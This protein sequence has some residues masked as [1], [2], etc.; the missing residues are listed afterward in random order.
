MRAGWDRCTVPSM[1]RD[2]LVLLLLYCLPLGTAMAQGVAHLAPVSGLN[3]LAA[4]IA[5]G[6]APLRSDLAR[7]A[8]TELA[9]VYADEAERAHREMRDRAKQRELSS[10]AAAV[11]DLAAEFAAL[12]ET[13]TPDTPVQVSIGP[14]HG[15][16]LLVEGRPVMVSSPRMREQV[17]FEQRVIAHFCALNQC[18]GL[19]DEPAMAT[20]A[21]ATGKTA[22]PQWSFSQVAGPVCG[23]G[24]G[25]EFQFMNADNIGRKR[26][27]CARIVSE[28]NTL[29]TALTQQ[30]AGGIRLDWNRLAIHPLPDGDEQVILNGEGDYLRLR[31]PVL[32]ARPE[33]FA[34]LR[35]WLAAK[36][37]GRLYPLVVLHAERMLEPPGQTLE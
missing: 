6:P 16:Y 2:L 35:S 17:A 1:Y 27:A 34:V 20:A 30:T 12:A 11:R 25:L 31:L 22:T 33:L 36:V 10:W 9:A 28:L 7:I 8:F 5:N 18:R 15:L 13:V 37:K 24:D 21:T 32:A 3:R 19:L 26:A 29:A 4:N 14:E 23:T